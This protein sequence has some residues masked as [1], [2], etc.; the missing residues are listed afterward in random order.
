MSEPAV[1][2][3]AVIPAFD[4]ERTI[5]DLVRRIKALGLHV[6]VVNDG[7]RDGTAA[8][9]ADAGALVISH[10]R[11]EGKGSAL[12][13]GFAHA[14][15]TRYDGVVTLDG[16]GQHDP[17]EIPE[18]I[19]QG[20]HQHAGLVVGNRLTNSAVMPR[21]RWWVNRLM[22]AIVSRVAG[23]TIPDSQCGFRFMRRELLQDVPLQARRFEIETELLCAAATR[24]WKIISL[25]VRSIY[26]NHHHSH[27]RPI[28]DGLRFLGVILRCVMLP[29]KR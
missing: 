5:G 1:R 23:V 3:C 20:E 19:R 11:N 7:S 6:V 22:S 8:A 2:Y 16:D 17:A 4:A 28:R 15:R 18:L 14:L 29:R 24:R 26:L 21:D 10:L 25:P 9:A 13:T 12:R 27:I